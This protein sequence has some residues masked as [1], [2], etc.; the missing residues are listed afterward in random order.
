MAGL[1]ILEREP[2][3]MVIVDQRM[4]E[5]TGAEFLAQ[6]I[7]SRPECIKIVLTGYADID[8]ITEAINRGRAHAFL[9]KPWDTRELLIAVRN[10]FETWRTEERRRALGATAREAAAQLRASLDAI[11]GGLTGEALAAATRAARETIDGLLRAAEE[12]PAKS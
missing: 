5:M 8:A 2:I 7:Y 4:P 1:R 12:P 6:S 10:G 9:R 3:A 11:D